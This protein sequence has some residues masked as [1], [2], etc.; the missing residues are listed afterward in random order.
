MTRGQA[1]HGFTRFGKCFAIG[2]PAN[3]PA[4]HSDHKAR[5]EAV[6]QCISLTLFKELVQLELGQFCR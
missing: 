4:I 2:F 5:I 3:C 1:W 6:F